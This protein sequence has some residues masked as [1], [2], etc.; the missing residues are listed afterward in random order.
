LCHADTEDETIEI[1]AA[2][3]QLYR[4]QGR[5]LERIYK[6]A[7]RVGTASIKANILDDVEKRRA[8]YDRFV[9]SQKFAQVDPWQERVNGKDAHEFAAMAEF[10]MPVAAE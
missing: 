9:H 6:W 5:Y 8:C 10:G 3:V 2:L 1:I 4:E 7:K